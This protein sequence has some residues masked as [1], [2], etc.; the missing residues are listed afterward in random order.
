MSQEDLTRRD[1]SGTGGEYEEEI[2]DDT[3]FKDASDAP[4]GSLALHDMHDA[5]SAVKDALESHAGRQE[6]PAIVKLIA[7]ELD[8]L[9]DKLASIRDMHAKH[10]PDHPAPED[11]GA[12]LDLDEDE[13]EETEKHVFDDDEERTT[14][15]KVGNKER[16]TREGGGDRVETDEKSR[17]RKSRKYRADDEHPLRK[18]S[19]D[20]HGQA[21]MRTRNRLQQQLMELLDDSF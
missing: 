8:E 14:P 10:Y 4:P 17:S 5:Y 11:G 9:E 13:D 6:H 18:K 2:G 16:S 12:D 20:R 19:L 1:A 3:S 15:A 21:L 7:H